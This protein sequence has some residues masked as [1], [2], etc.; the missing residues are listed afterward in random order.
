MSASPPR[1]PSRPAGR[2]RSSGRSTGRTRPFDPFGVPLPIWAA[3][4][5]DAQELS[6]TAVSQLAGQRIRS[7]SLAVWVRR[8]GRWWPVV[9][10]A[11]CQ[12]EQRRWAARL[13]GP[14]GAEIWVAYRAVSLQPIQAPPPDA[15]PDLPGSRS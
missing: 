7:D 8:G 5:R 11:W 2:E 10:T 4:W 6:P 3:D 9:L 1:P 14:D 12:F 13:R 15:W